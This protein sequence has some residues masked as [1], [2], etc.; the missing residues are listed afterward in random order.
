MAH[1][2]KQDS[3]L[4]EIFQASSEAGADPFQNLLRYLVQ[5]L[6]EEELTAFL[7]A[8]PYDRTD[9]RKGYRNGYKPRT[10]KTRVGTLEL[11]VPKDR[12][13]RFQTELF[14]KYQR[15]EKALVLALTE[16]Y[17]Q[18]VS[19]RKVKKITEQLCGL[20]ISRSQ[21]SR[22]SQGLDE[23]I[24][25]WRTRPLGD[26]Y[27]YLVIDARVERIR[28]D[29]A[30]IPQSALLVVGINE[31]GYREVLGV[32]CADSESEDS[33]SMVFNELKERGLS[34][35][36][37]VVSDNH[38]GLTSA[39][40]RRFQ[41]VI[42]QRCQA[43]FIRNV[44][45]KAPKKDRGWILEYLREITA[46]ATYESARKRLDKAIETFSE[47]HPNVAKILEEGGEDILAVY[48]L[49]EHHRKKMR[50]TNMVERF[51]QELKRR[52]RVIRVFP[53]ENACVRLIS[54]LSMEANE[55]WMER[56]YL[57]MEA[58]EMTCRGTPDAVPRHLE[59]AAR[60][61]HSHS[62]TTA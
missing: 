2:E 20:E 31:D 9:Q 1:P 62:T 52:T 41:G 8:E 45:S 11:L 59:N 30:I 61:P 48:A 15:N 51:N 21:V 3:G 24:R 13:G 34:G 57:R 22:L 39:I 37:F 7:H 53:N 58:V 12:E 29:G 33:W 44:L 49:P 27:P 43:H 23:E 28:R 42:R 36:S 18:G 60:L 46:S 17:L 16:M 40:A 47:T 14:A 26:R 32:W 55:E 10:F 56:R 35:V 25:K 54:A 38:S 5:Q 6:L 4:Y 19:T 50:T